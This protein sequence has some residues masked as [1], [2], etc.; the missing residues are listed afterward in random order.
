MAAFDR[1]D[2]RQLWRLFRL[3]VRTRYT[4]SVLG[5]V[6]A[7]ANPLIMLTLFT[8]VF[9]FVLK[10]RLPGSDD[11]LVYSLWLIAGLG[12]WLGIGDCLQSGASSVVMSD[13]LVKNLAFKTELLPLAATLLGFVPILVS[14]AFIGLLLPWTGVPLGLHL[15]AL[16]PL[17]GVLYLFLAGLAFFLAALTV[18]LRDMISVLPNLLTIILF[19]TP[20][21]YSPQLV[22]TRLDWLLGINPFYHFTDSFRVIILEGALPSLGRSLVVTALS[23]VLFWLGLTSFRRV[24]G[25]FDSRL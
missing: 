1:G 22:P 8:F 9:G 18:F 4:G 3:A 6:W 20:I 17:L 24:K 10:I 16:V 14:L 11:T 23:L 7:V 15:L 13:N 2:L 19:G 25:F 12:P 5:G 21:V